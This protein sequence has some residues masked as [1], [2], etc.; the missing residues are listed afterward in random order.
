MFSGGKDSLA[1]LLRLQSD[2]AHPPRRLLTTCNES[3]ARVALH[4]TPMALIRAQAGSLDL[5]L[6]EI[7]L[8]DGCDN[9]TYLDRVGSALGPLINDG[10][11][12]VAFG[13]LFL[14]DIRSFREKQMHDLGLE[15]VFPLWHEDTGKLA[16]ELIGSGIE[17]T[18][19]C[20]DLEAL[21]ES[22]LG[23]TWDESFVDELPSG[24]DPCGENGE[25]HTLV[26]DAPNMRSRIETVAAG[27]HV[28]HGRFCML[29]LQPA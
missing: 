25:F 11:T 18:V 12:R 15:C 24:C 13:D 27:R 4:G 9:E 5:P 22:L 20:V 23:R 28:S 10:L 26:V 14:D 8:P 2:D 6:T 16:R 17:A 29:D 7:P 19:C 21:P 3:N 1:A